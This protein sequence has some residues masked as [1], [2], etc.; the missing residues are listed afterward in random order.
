MLCGDKMEFAIEAWPRSQIDGAVYGEFVMHVGGHRLGDPSDQALLKGCRNW[1]RVLDADAPMRREPQLDNC[2]AE[3][4][5]RLAWDEVMASS[6]VAHPRFPDAFRRF[7]ISHA[8]MSALDRFDVLLMLT[9][10]GESRVIWRLNG[11]PAR[12]HLVGHGV[13]RKVIA[14]AVL[15]MDRLFG[16]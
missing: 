3:E 10:A 11:G 13:I 5:M 7:H 2:D 8:G 15:G 16:A 4:V 12:E 14:A 9:S 6:G 1:L